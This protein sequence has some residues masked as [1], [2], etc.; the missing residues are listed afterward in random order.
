MRFDWPM[1]RRVAISLRRS[2]SDWR[3]EP[4][5]ERTEG[6]CRSAW[7]WQ[8]GK[9]ARSWT[10]RDLMRMNLKGEDID[11]ALWVEEQD[12]FQTHTNGDP[13]R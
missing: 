6:R 1:V 4:G 13:C 2:R 8:D 7:N 3:Q 11:W 10:G 5:R 9:T 12:H